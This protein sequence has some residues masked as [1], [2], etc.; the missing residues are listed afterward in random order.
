MRVTRAVER[1]VAFLRT[2]QGADGS[3]PGQWAKEYPVG[4]TAL[5]LYALAKSQVDPTEPGM[6][7]ATELVRA[8]PLATTYE[9]AVSILAFDAL[10]D[11]ALD[12]WIRV[13][14]RWLEQRSD[15]KT[16]L[17]SYPSGPIDG[18]PSWDLSNTQMAALGLWAAERHGYHASR[19]VWQRLVRTLPTLRTPS[20]AFAYTIDRRQ[21]PASGSMTVAGMTLLDLGLSRIAAA[22]RDK[23]HATRAARTLSDAWAWLDRRF[24]AEGNPSGEYAYVS[25]WHLYF[26]YGIE[27]VAALS[28]RAK[29]GGRAWYPEVA[30]HLLE[31]QRADGS[32]LGTTWD[33]ATALLV[34]RKA[35]ATSLGV[36]SPETLP[37]DA[38]EDGATPAAARPAAG[39]PFL[40]R[41]LLLGPFPN[42]DDAG[43]STALVPETS[44]AP[45]AGQRQGGLSWIA[46]RSGPL[47]SFT[48]ALA[49]PQRTVSYAFSYVHALRDTDVRL[50]IGHDDGARA[51]LDG[52]VVYE[53][54]FHEGCSPDDRS[55]PLH[56]RAGPH[57]LLVKVEEWAGGT[58][59]YARLAHPDGSD[60]PEVVPSLLP[61]PPTPTDALRLRPEALSLEDMLRLLPT[62][63]VATIGFDA[64]LDLDRLVL[65]DQARDHP[66]WSLRP[67][68]RR[69]QPY[70]G[71][72]GFLAVEPSSPTS[73]AQVVWRLKLPS[74]APTV[75]LTVSG[76]PYEFPQLSCDFV[77]RISVFDGTAHPLLERVVTSGPGSPGGWEN[78]AVDVR[79]FAGKDVL[80]VIEAA[81]GGTHPW[82]NEEA[83]FGE[84]TIGQAG[85]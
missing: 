48:A 2:Q 69:D 59:F 7:K 68:A 81:S 31:V 70:P 16:G 72:L 76:D 27:R 61:S 33:T 83:F 39:I 10:A 74:G 25:D 47:V 3:F 50:W 67:V 56:L 84:I 18:R 77:L 54:H 80:L 36:R 51:W 23:P 29:I 42:P 12:D 15:L 52:R 19:D 55:V 45:R 46:W 13:A 38:P 58:G 44:V 14:A 40:T 41:W 1:G 11:P 62:D 35:T 26:L 34:L 8:R 20:G 79:A 17:S 4:H 85:R 63:P 82:M 9:T 65:R 24:S 43:L 53:R 60:A 30:R 66:R 64:P 32:W 49:A 75:R 22:D 6:R 57:R 71:V 37:A 21:L 73:P 78:V 5:A 28:G